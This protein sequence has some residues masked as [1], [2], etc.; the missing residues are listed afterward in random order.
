MDD[1]AEAFWAGF[2]KEI[3][4]PV[5][6]RTMGQ[7]LASSKDRGDWGL[8]VLSPS[9]LRFRRTPGENW[10]ASLFRSS[11][12]SVP[13]E[14]EADIVIP[15]A[16]ITRI[17][18]PPKKFLDALFGSPFLVFSVFYKESGAAPEGEGCEARFAIDPKSDIPARLKEFAKTLP[19]PG[20]A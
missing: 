9:G 15:Y 13:K 3:G 8:F 18:F 12:V 19:E 5:L 20:R 10:F 7:Y 4:E 1:T 17:A 14:K 11:S 16:D 6:A 2:E